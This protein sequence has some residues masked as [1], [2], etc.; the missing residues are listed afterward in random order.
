MSALVTEPEVVTL[1]PKHLSGPYRTSLNLI[2]K[3]PVSHH[4]SWKHAHELFDHLGTVQQVSNH[5]FE[6]TV[7]SDTLIFLKP[8]T[9]HL[10]ESEMLEL[11]AFLKG[12]GWA[13]NLLTNQDAA[14]ASAHQVDQAAVVV[15][16]RHDASVYHFNRSGLAGTEP[17]DNWPKFEVADGGHARFLYLITEAVAS[18]EKIIVIGAL[19]KDR[20]PIE[21][22]AKHLR[23]HHKHAKSRAV[24]ELAA[25]VHH[26]SVPA[27]R[28]LA[29]AAL[30]IEV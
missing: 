3:N 24:H 10:T 16:S 20:Q 21:D 15:I 22:L 25:E 11:R 26:L 23:E 14:Q 29:A 8:H 30:D 13:P 2:F 17:T 28:T 6:I 18:D 12:A 4:L 1:A 5:R 27:I 9:A 19:D 7:G